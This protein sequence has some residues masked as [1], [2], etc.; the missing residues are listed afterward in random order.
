MGVIESHVAAI[1]SNALSLTRIIMGGDDDDDVNI[2]FRPTL[3]APTD[4]AI[5]R[6]VCRYIF[7]IALNTHLL[8]SLHS[9][10]S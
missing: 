4:F 8:V 2:L 6:Y 10:A 9:L 5:Q 7:A 3:K 1:A